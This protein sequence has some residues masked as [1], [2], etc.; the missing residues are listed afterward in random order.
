M[1]FLKVASFITCSFIK[2]EAPTQM[3]SCD[4]CEILR[5]KCF[6]EH[7]HLT[8]SSGQLDQFKATFIKSKNIESNCFRNT[9]ISILSLYI[10]YECVEFS[11]LELLSQITSTAKLQISTTFPFPFLHQTEAAIHFTSF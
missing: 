5:N 1:L 11:H 3:F 10:P 7:L 8:V 4:F 2:K 9:L 6:T